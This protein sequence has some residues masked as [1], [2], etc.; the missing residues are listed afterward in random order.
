MHRHGRTDTSAPAL[1]TLAATDRS[2]TAPAA[3]FPRHLQLVLALLSFT[4]TEHSSPTAHVTQPSATHNGACR[5]LYNL[6]K[7]NIMEDRDGQDPSH[8]PIIEGA[9]YSF[10]ALA[11]HHKQ[12]APK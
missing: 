5:C 10:T 4:L 1:R 12:G 2:N 9:K 7:A 6:L 3:A 8:Q 11:E